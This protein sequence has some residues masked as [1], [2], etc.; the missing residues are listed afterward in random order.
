M[1]LMLYRDAVAADD[2]FGDALRHVEIIGDQGFGV[3]Q[4]GIASA[5]LRAGNFLGTALEIDA[6][7]TL[8]AALEFALLHGEAIGVLA[9]QTVFDFPNKS[10]LGVIR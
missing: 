3:F 2:A 5:A 10:I 6:H 1:R 8:A 4:G 9:D 7:F